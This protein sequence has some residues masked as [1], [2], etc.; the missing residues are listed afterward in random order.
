MFS[1]P[2]EKTNFQGAWQKWR[3]NA[4]GAR[5]KKSSWRSVDIQGFRTHNKYHF[6]LVYSCVCEGLLSSDTSF[7]ICGRLAFGGKV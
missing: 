5:A 7:A 2:H 1:E 3:R 4:V 6:S